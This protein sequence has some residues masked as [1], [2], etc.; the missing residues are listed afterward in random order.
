M[1]SVRFREA[2][3]AQDKDFPII[4]LTASRQAVNFAA[5]MADAREVD[6]WLTKEAP[7]IPA[8]DE[9]SSRA[10]HYLLE[11]LHL[12]ACLRDWYRPEMDWELKWKLDYARLYNG[13][14][15]DGCQ[16][17]VSQKAADIFNHWIGNGPPRST[18]FYKAIQDCLP[19]V[20]NVVREPHRSLAVRLVARRVAV[21]TLLHTARWQG[22]RPEWDLQE[23]ASI[24]PGRHA[25][26]TGI[27][28]GE[29][30]Y[31]SD[32]VNF[33]EQLWLRSYLPDLVDLLLEE[34][35]IWLQNRRW[36]RNARQ[37][38]KLVNQAAQRQRVR[39]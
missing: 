1:K 8:D 26:P 36:S 33:H 24:V 9:N 37:I 29:I 20:G 16:Q 28:R 15:W 17:W 18:T 12:F 38:R 39:P 2:V 31:P 22:G 10:V 21:A 13:P 23:W 5:V 27:Y 32:V 35:Y 25:R 19:D 7:D 4:I 14:D 34:E 3:K 30:R 6:G 11:R